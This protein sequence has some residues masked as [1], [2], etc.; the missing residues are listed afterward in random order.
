MSW[1]GLRSGLDRR[2]SCHSEYEAKNL[3]AAARRHIYPPFAW[4]PGRFLAQARDRFLTPLRMSHCGIGDFPSP[5]RER[6]RVSG[7]T[8]RRLVRERVIVPIRSF[9][10]LRTRNGRSK[11]S[12]PT[13]F[14]SA[15]CP[16]TLRGPSPRTRSVRNFL[17]AR[18]LAP[19]TLI[20]RRRTR[21]CTPARPG[22]PGCPSRK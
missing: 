19:S 7:T 1:R 3:A 10:S 22:L 16:A 11:N 13:K 17:R 12:A 14:D 5:S 9:E 15:R 6:G 21:T 4:Q 20:A 8:V 2:P 18:P